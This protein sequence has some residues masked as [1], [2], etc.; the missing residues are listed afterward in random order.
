MFIHEKWNL[1]LFVLVWVHFE[2]LVVYNWSNEKKLGGG[3]GLLKVTWSRGKMGREELKTF[4]PMNSEVWIPFFL[5][6][7][8]LSHSG[9][10]LVGGKDLKDTKGKESGER[11]RERDV[12]SVTGGCCILQ[13]ELENT[14]PY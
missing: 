4:G 5:A 7:C 2:C 9:P 14:Q 10:K 1:L 6:A 8:G 11:E 13:F 3:G 12:L